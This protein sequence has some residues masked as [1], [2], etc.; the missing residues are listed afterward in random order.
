M[1]KEQTEAQEA[2]KK[3][4]ERK[5]K[6]YLASFEGEEFPHK[7][8]QENFDFAQKNGYSDGMI[9]GVESFKTSLRKQI[10]EKIKYLKNKKYTHR[11]MS[12][13]D[14]YAAEQL[15]SVLA[16]LETLKPH[17]G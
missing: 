13:Y 10:E 3:E 15:E 6:L 1:T 14:L 9:D 5:S 12:A 7:T 8:W 17:K 2:W 11:N 4:A 16:L